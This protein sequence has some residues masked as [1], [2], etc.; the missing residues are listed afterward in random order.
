MKRISCYEQTDKLI[1]FLEEINPKMAFIYTPHGARPALY[2][3]IIDNW[4]T[5][6]EFV[7][8]C[9]EV[10]TVREPYIFYFLA[11]KD[12]NDHIVEKTLWTEEQMAERISYY[13]RL[14][15]QNLS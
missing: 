3:H 13:K 6:R 1:K 2:K 15:C 11:L 5:Y 7:Q 12:G 14:N 8:Y 4:T 9:K 10:D